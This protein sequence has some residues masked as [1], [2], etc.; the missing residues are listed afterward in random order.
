MPA[1]EPLRDYQEQGV[2]WLKAALAN[3]RGV[4]LADDPGLGKTR[5][6]LAAADQ[7]NAQRILIVC[8]A[9]ARRVWQN[10]I[11]TWFPSWS[12]RVLVLESGV[13]AIDIEPQLGR[14]P[15]IVIVGYDEFSNSKSR[16]V[17]K[18]RRL[19]WDLLILD[20]A[21][22]L[23]NPSNRTQALYGRPG[24]TLGLQATAPRRSSCRAR[25][26]PTT[27]ANYS[28]I[29]RVFW[30]TLAQ[31][32]APDKRNGR[33]PKSSSRTAIR[34]IA[35]PC[36]GVRSPARRTRTNCVSHSTM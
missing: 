13:K 2:C 5:Q 12:P 20:E 1:L 26:R 23:K 19:R 3:H 30:P 25:R 14:D 8:P 10:E 15:A 18:L 31:R 11:A 34:A 17:T 35:T 16:V 27:P 7:L 29:A 6:A 36:S 24:T 28:S 21:H 9:G 33:I 32:A 4:L 22:Y